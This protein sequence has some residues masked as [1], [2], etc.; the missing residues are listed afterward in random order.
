MAALI[1]SANYEVKRL[2]LITKLKIKEEAGR[3][4]SLIA[5]ILTEDDR[6]KYILTTILGMAHDDQSEENRIVAVR[7]PSLES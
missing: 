2:F 4:F 7:V 1:Y 3:I 5:P 6:G